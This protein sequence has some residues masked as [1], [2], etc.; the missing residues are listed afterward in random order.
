MH[1]FCDSEKIKVEPKHNE[2]IWDF[3]TLQNNSKDKKSLIN[4]IF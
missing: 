4:V 3:L 2:K 1:F